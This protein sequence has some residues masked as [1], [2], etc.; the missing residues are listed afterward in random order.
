MRPELVRKHAHDISFVNGPQQSVGS[1]SD[2]GADA[3]V[4]RS[5]GRM[6]SWDDRG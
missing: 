6:G 1:S 5:R 4:V 2:G 3:V